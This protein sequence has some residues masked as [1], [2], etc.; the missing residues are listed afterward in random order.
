MAELHAAPEEAGIWF[1][2]RG[3]GHHIDIRNSFAVG[4]G[5]CL[6]AGKRQGI[7][8]LHVRSAMV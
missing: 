5:E 7:L 1:G 8:S 6:W 4:G 3:A 2:A